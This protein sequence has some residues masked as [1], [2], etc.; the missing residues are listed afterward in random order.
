MHPRD[1]GFGRLFDS[2]RD[3]VIVADAHTGQIVLWNP[4][5][6]GTFGYSPAEART[7]P[8]DALVPERLRAQHRA[9]RRR[10][11]Q[12][13]QGRFIDANAVLQLPALH[14]AGHELQVELTLSPLPDP[15]GDRR[16]VLAIVREVTERARLEEALRASAESFDSLFH[17]TAEGVA[18]HDHGRHVTVNQ[19]LAAM[20]G[21]SVT[22]LLGRSVLDVVGP[23]S[24]AIVREKMRT[25]DERPYEVVGLRKDGSTFPAEVAGKAIRYQGRPMRLVTVRDISERKRLEAA[26]L[27]ASEA[28]FLT[29]VAASPVPISISRLADGCFCEVNESFLALSG[30]RREEVIGHTANDLGLS[31]EPDGRAMLVELVREQ[32]AVRNLEG[33]YRTRSGEVRT[34]LVSAAIITIA[35]EEC[36]LSITLDITERKQAEE[37]H[38]TLLLREQA[39]RAQAEEAA[40][41]RQEFLTI[42]AHELKTPLT[43]VKGNVQL[44]ARQLSPPA[45]DP[46]RVARLLERVQ[47][48][49]KRLEVLVGD[50]LDSSR[51][52]Q[53]RLPLRLER[54]DLVVVAQQVVERFALS[55]DEPP[56]HTLTLDAPVP[57]VG[58]WDVARLE[59][60]LTN[61]V[62]NALKYSPAG[63]TI[64]VAVGCSGSH[65]EVV[66]SD[67]GVGIPVAEQATLFQ[68]FVRGSGIRHVVE[69]TGLGLYITARIVEQHG[70]TI[71]C[72]SELGVG[73]S[74]TIRLPLVPPW[75]E[76]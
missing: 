44:L 64:R 39:A 24:H 3:A 41:L 65:A 58:R 28:R 27:Q 30:Y 54:V 45:A 1:L 66:V 12:T 5:A 56:R 15:A 20:L 31:L 46:A 60:V 11:S 33:L 61:L 16:L 22:E 74:F 32:Q 25:G 35:G 53:G 38:A 63:G 59:Q 50:L 70:G 36:L 9:G 69:G 2:I 21:Y 8:L 10:Y 4:A 76:G 42:A 6:T 48:Q 19:T 37:A 7:L 73:S 13:G 52:Q 68:P 26:A 57:V 18:I 14:R 29:V 49:I 17:A 62:A 71:T 40:R 55:L 47:G 43:T 51:L 34:A 75:E 72:Q 23:D 67:Q